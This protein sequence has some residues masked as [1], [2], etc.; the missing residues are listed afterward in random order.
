MVVLQ[1]RHLSTYLLLKLGGNDNPTAAD[2]TAALNSV[3]VDVSSYASYIL[4]HQ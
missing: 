1:M 4:M 3:G 2:V